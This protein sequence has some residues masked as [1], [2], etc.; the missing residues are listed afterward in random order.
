MSP[1]QVDTDVPGRV[2]ADAHHPPTAVGQVLLLLLVLGSFVSFAASGRL[3]VRLVLDGAISFAFIPALEV[4]AFYLVVLRWRE[5]FAFRNGLRPFLAGNV[6]W[7]YWLVA[8]GALLSVVPP[9][10]IGFGL[11]EFVVASAIVPFV[12]AFW[13]DVR[14]LTECCGRPKSDA[15]RDAL[16]HRAIGW[17]LGILYF[18]GIAIW[19][20]VQPTMTRWFGL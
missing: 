18:F 9:R 14:H 15:I 2:R 17:G 20:L 13:N 10:T 11:V 7:L 1:T 8:I 6:P 3:S 5:R 16:L 12:W 4:L 19:S